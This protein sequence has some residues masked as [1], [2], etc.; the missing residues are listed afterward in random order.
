MMAIIGMFFQDGLTGALVTTVLLWTPLRKKPRVPN[1]LEYD[2]SNRSATRSRL[3]LGRLGELCGLSSAS[4][5][6]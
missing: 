4:L 6:E 2:G 1:G 5:R 3:G